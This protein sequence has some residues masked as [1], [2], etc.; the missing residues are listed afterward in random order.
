M[1]DLTTGKESKLILYFATPMLLG[2][3]FQQL[4]NV[5]DSIIVGNYLGKEALGAVGA[6]FPIIF[7]LI[8][9][10][11]GIGSG[12]TI[13]IAQYFGAKKYDMVTKAIDTLYIIFFFA[14][15]VLTAIGI[16]FSEDIFRL[17]QLPDEIIPQAKTYL[18]TYLI[19]LMAFFGFNGTSAILRGLGD[20]KTPL[21]FLVIASIFNIGFDFLFIV[22]FKWGIAGAAWATV[23]AQTGAFITAILYLNKTHKI[24]NL[25]LLTI[26]F[27]RSI[28][29]K[30][31]KI[32]LPTGLQHTFVSLGMI[33]MFRIVNEFGTDVVAA[34]SVAGRIDRLAI[35]PAMNFSQALS[36][37][38][39]QN[40]G[41][42]KTN[43]V[44]TG[45]YATFLMSSIVSIVLSLTII[46][47]RHFLMDLF[48]NDLEV[49]EI[50]ARY[51]ITVSSFY[52]VFNTMFLFNGVLRGAGDTIVP[53]FLTLMSLWLIRLPLAW[54]LSQ[55]IGETGIWWAIP[56]AWLT[57][58]FFSGIYYLTGNWK[59]RVIVSPPVVN[60][61]KIPRP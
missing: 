44:K 3:I 49:I 12:G 53:M 2:N 6:S 8:S 26:K 11:I 61:T 30:T 7:T 33:A 54:F 9:F 35:L 34:Y 60:G 45:L 41:A 46:F 56:I 37:F 17:T 40:L 19:G 38:V 42:N 4:Y 22:G 36:T 16:Y 20:S 23:I 13:V 25:N 52:L 57:S 14:S 39:G 27:D 10:I 31:I 28:F 5:V 59:K 18:N 58:M 29:V 55:R 51:L 43:R 50:G 21:Y 24:I 48:T 47:G 32:G 1:K 15:I